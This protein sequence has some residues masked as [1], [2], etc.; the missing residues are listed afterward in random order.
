MSPHPTVKEPMEREFRCC[1]QCQ[2]VEQ[3]RKTCDRC[4]GWGEVPIHGWDSGEY[5]PAARYV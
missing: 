3:E 5:Y 4:Y 2:A 1:P